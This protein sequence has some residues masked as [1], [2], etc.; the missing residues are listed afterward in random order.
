VSVFNRRNAA[1]GWLAWSVG[2]RV[3]KHKAKEAV[4]KVDTQTK[5]PN[6]TAIA[7]LLAGAVGAAVF[8]RRRSAEDELSDE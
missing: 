7:L 6:R 1:L 4:P 2:K 3:M 5:R 8:W